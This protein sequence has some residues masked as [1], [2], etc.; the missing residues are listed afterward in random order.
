MI[1]MH[2]GFTFPADYDMSIIDR[3]ITE[4]GH[5]MDGFAGL[6]FKSYLTG[7][8]TSSQAGIAENT[9]A[10]F[11]LWQNAEAMNTF[12]CGS[13]FAGLTQAFGWP[14]VKTWSVWHARNSATISKARFATCASVPIAPYTN[15]HA[16]R[17]EETKRADAIVEREHALAAL[18]GFDPTNWTLVRFQLWESTPTRLFAEDRLYEVGHVSAG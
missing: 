5:M 7:R 8:T 4:K 11:Y 6:V 18:V 1:A 13:G 3:R 9:Y 12:L 10:P 14:S 15:L 17:M 16:L 2:Y